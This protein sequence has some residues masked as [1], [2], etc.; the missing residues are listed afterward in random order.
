MLTCIHII[1]AKESAPIMRC[2]GLLPPYA[3]RRCLNM[4]PEDLRAGSR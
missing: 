3:D 2:C 1:I 4:A